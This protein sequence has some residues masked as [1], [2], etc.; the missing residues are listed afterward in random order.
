MPI[1][2]KCGKSLTSEQAL[3]YHLNKKYKC[4]TWNCSICAT[5]FNTKFDLKIH[6]LSCNKNN[7]PINNNTSATTSTKPST[8]VLL[9]IYNNIDELIISVNDNDVITSA[10]PNGLKK[11]GLHINDVLGNT[12]ND[13]GIKIDKLQNICKN[14]YIYTN[15][16]HI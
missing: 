1:C 12:I 13:I 4:G 7:I 6:E 9:E 5:N 14:I 8:D 11:Y 2:P 10:S 16:K 3:T 15:L